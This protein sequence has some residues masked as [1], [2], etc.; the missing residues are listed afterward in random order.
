MT[1]FL[2]GVDSRNSADQTLWSA[3]IRLRPS[4]RRRDDSQSRPAC[5]SEEGGESGAEGTEGL[6]G[7]CRHLRAAGAVGLLILFREREA[8]S[9]KTAKSVFQ[10]VKQL[11]AVLIYVALCVKQLL[12]LWLTMLAEGL[13]LL[14]GLVVLPQIVLLGRNM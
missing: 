2:Q 9:L 4:S 10:Y 14:R 12:F 11:C 6:K 5:P 3:R 7:T 8:Q 1:C 13:S